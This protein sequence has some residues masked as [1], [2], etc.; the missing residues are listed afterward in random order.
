MD[1]LDQF[2]RDLLSAAMN[3]EKGKHTKKFMRDEGS[4]LRKKTLS[5]AKS[6][7][8]KRTGNLFKGIKRGKVYKRDGDLA[9]RVYGADAKSEESAPHIHLVNNGHRIVDKNGEE[10]GFVEGV[11]FFESAERDF[12]GEFYGDI[13]T[14]ID[15][16]LDNHGL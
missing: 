16:L 7:V 15:E 1:D 5:E 12:Q 14:M 8:K 4:K 6:K 2:T 11:H 3:F 13:E 9:I 10:H